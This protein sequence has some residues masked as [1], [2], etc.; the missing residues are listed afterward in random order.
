MLAFG[1]RDPSL[2]YARN[3]Q[4]RLTNCFFFDKHVSEG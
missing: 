4:P 1:L 2:S 3:S